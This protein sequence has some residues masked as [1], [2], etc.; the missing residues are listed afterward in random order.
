MGRNLVLRSR[1]RFGEWEIE[2]EINFDKEIYNEVRY[3]MAG[4]GKVSYGRVRFG[5]V[6]Y[7]GEIFSAVLLREPSEQIFFYFKFSF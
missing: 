3:G 5:L 2:F 7:S 6:R 1:P 4:C